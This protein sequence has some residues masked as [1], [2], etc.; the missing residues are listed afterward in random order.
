VGRYPYDDG[1]KTM[2]HTATDIRRVCAEVLAMPEYEPKPDGTTFC[3][4]ALH[5]ILSILGLPEFCWD[6]EKAQRLMLANDIADKLENTCKEL[7]FGMAFDEANRGSIVVAALKM[8]VHGH[9]AIIYPSPGLY[10]SG[11]WDRNDVPF[12]ANV[13]GFDATGESMSG[14]RPMNWAFGAKPRLWQVE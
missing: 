13:G 11:K 9:V 12:V 14:V 4:Q 8:P 5:N 1:A 6:Q 7:S 2:K 10:T 3:N